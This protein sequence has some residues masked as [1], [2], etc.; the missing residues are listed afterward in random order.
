MNSSS[1][2]QFVMDLL[3]VPKDNTTIQ[4]KNPMT[5]PYPEETIEIAKS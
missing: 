2:V 3:Y 4:S 5:V 1:Q